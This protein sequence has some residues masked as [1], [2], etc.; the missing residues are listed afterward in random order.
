[1]DTY[2]MSG[3]S[4]AIADLDNDGWKDLM[5]ARGNV[6]ND[7]AL[8]SP[9]HSEEPPAVFRNLATGKFQNVSGS[10]GPDFQVPSIHRGLA[11]GDLDNDGRLDAV[12]SVLN[13]QAKIFH[14]TTHNSNH[15]ILLKLTGTKSNR[16]AIGAKV[17]LTTAGGLV[18]YNHVTTST[19][20]ACSSDSRVHFGLGASAVAKEIAITWPSGIQQVLHDVPADRIVAITE[21]AH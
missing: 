20:Y 4:N 21:P 14:N 15:W 2:E 1:M 8:Y 7:M 19:G 3:W 10:A 13:G 18:Q 17:R 9:R 12:V 11:I 6:Q 5:V 16:M